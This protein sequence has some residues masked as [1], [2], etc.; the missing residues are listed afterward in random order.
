MDQYETLFQLLRQK[1]QEGNRC[2]YDLSEI[3]KGPVSLEHLRRSFDT[4]GALF[5]QNAFTPEAYQAAQLEMKNAYSFDVEPLL[6]RDQLP[7]SNLKVHEF[8]GIDKHWPTGILGNKNVGYLLLHPED[9][10]DKTVFTASTGEKSSVCLMGGYKANLALMTHPTSQLTMALIFRLGDN[11]NGHL[12]VDSG[13]VRRGDLTTP[14]YDYYPDGD[15]N[16]Q[17]ALAMGPNEG[18][19][20]LVYGLYS[21]DPEV[22]AEIRRITKDENL[23][24][25]VGFR[26]LPKEFQK[27][28]METFGRAGCLASAGPSELVIFH[29]KVLHAEMLLTKDGKYIFK[30]DK[31]TTT[32]RYVVGTHQPKGFTEKGWTETM[33]LARNGICFHPYDRTFVK[34]PSGQNTVC[35]KST[36]FKRPRKKSPHEIEKLARF[37]REALEEERIA[38]WKQEENPRILHCLGISQPIDKLFSDPLARLVMQ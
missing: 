31:N 29:Q 23:F 14:H 12:S 6:D 17:Q 21:N 2:V 15:I 38:K 16:R 25:K 37:C 10:K 34:Q 13:K 33:Y 30:N 20:R 9:S 5:I 3:Q 11:P 27:P 28:I 1:K 4:N 8:S 7:P 35:R 32:E 26:T 18:R 24:T 36:M 22:Q 19:V